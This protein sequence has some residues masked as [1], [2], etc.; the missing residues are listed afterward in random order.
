[1]TNTLRSR[2]SSSGTDKKRLMMAY[3]G[4]DAQIAQ[5]AV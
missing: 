3:Y 5:C 4:K 1:M 2:P